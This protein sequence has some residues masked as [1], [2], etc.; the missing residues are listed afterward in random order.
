MRVYAG[1][2]APFKNEESTINAYEECLLAVNY[3][4]LLAEIE[5][6]QALKQAPVACETLSQIKSNPRHSTIAK[7]NAS[8]S[9]LKG[10]RALIRKD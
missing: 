6:N 7:H 5:F 1:P 8:I 10:C 4:L 9:K 3:Q 2:W